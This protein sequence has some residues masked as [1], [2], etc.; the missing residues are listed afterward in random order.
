M[1]NTQHTIQLPE[2]EFIIDALTFINSD[3]KLLKNIYT[4]WR[5]LCSQLNLVGARGVNLPE[6]LSEVLSALRWEQ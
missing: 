1:K 3:R 6:G 4:D 2:G 5:N